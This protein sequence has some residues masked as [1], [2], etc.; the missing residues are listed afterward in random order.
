M[1][2]K[3]QWIEGLRKMRRNIYVAGQKVD[4]DDEMMTPTINSMGLSF[5]YAHIA[6]YQ[7][8]TTATSHLN[9]EKINRFCHVHQ[10]TEDLHKKQDV[11]RLLTQKNGHCIMR[12]M[13]TD[14]MNAI[15]CVAFEADKENN[16]A[17]EYYQNFLKWLERFQKEDLV[18]C[19]AQTDV[20]GNRTQRPSQQ[21]DPDA[22]LRVVERKND[23]I[24]VRGCKINNSEASQSDEI[25]V[26]PTRSLLPEE[27]D[28]AVA[29]AVPA[30]AEGLK[31]VVRPA[32]IRSRKLFPKGFENGMTDSTSIF[33]DVFIPWDRVFL[34]GE[35][36]HGGIL[37]LLF[38]LYH[39]HSYTGCK[40]AVSEVLMGTIALAAEYNGIHKQKHVRDKLAEMIMITEL[41][42]AAGFTGSEKGSPKVFV[43][44][45]GLVPYGPGTYIPD[46]IYCN[47]GRCISGEAYYR[48]ME[49][50]ADVAGG[51]PASLPYEEDWANPET[52]EFLEKYVIRNPDVSAENQHLLWRH[53]ADILC[54]A[55]GGAAAMSA[56]H[57]GGSPIMEKIAITSQYD[58]EV[59]KKMAKKI[60]GIKD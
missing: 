5:D 50:L 59:R 51:I 2:T 22:Y 46:S 34:C 19:C 23:G 55:W 58:I 41:A 21:M 54:S 36:Q 18:G 53:V 20:K 31:Q 28:W 42:Y 8:L 39:R 38:A 27:A 13:G 10:S 48:E 52:K 30:D 12:C 43:P 3:E 11:T 7:D 17:T 26:L 14:A 16:G 33:D 25:L 4:R 44:G 9:G 56:L 49:T 15:S 40:P 60:V 35:T 24:V 29:F 47:V 45:R 6:E 1:R 37:A 57:G 32:N